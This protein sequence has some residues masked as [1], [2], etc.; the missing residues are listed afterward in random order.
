MEG[1]DGLETKRRQYIAKA[2]ALIDERTCLLDR[3]SYELLKNFNDLRK[4]EVEVLK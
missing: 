4:T 1:V 2:S 3:L